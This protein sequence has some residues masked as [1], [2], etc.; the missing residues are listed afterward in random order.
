MS[1][2]LEDAR[3]RKLA[4]VLYLEIAAL[5]IDVET[6]YVP[7]LDLTCGEICQLMRRLGDNRAGLRAVMAADDPDLEAVRQEGAA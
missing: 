5:G 6:G 1:Y 7:D 4:R 2:A 3:R